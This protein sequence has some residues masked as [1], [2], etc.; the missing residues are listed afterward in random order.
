[1]SSLAIPRMSVEEYL[2]IDREAEVKSE[3]HDGE[4]FPIDS[5]SLAHSTIVANTTRRAAEELDGKPCRV[6]RQPLR[7]RVTPARFVYPDLLVICGQPEMTDEVQDT[8]TNPKVIIEVLSPSTGGYDYGPKFE[9]Y[10]KLPSFVEYLLIKQ[11]QPK[12]E[13]FRKVG[14]ARWEL[15]TYEGLET[16]VPIESIRINLRLSDVYADVEFPALTE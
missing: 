4:M 8:I 9:F 14:G 7:V 2:A 11:D 1:M 15:S 13:V 10:R 6:L 5:V 3:F 16:V 12:I